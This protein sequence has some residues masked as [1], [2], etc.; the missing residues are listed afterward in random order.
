MGSC[1][2]YIRINYTRCKLNFFLACDVVKL[3]IAVSKLLEGETEC[4]L[5]GTAPD[6]TQHAHTYTPR[7]PTHRFLPWYITTT[8]HIIDTIKI[9]RQQRYSSIYIYHPELS[10]YVKFT[11]PV[12]TP[13]A[14]TCDSKKI[15][16]Y[17]LT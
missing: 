16:T 5:R 9:N 12:F 1:K 13:C 6:A 14:T 17:I 2:S 4:V 7:L 11:N 10:V 3:F 8:V 15:Y